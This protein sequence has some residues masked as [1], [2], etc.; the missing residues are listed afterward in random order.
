M[1]IRVTN[2]AEKKVILDGLETE[3]TWLTF[4]ADIRGLLIFREYLFDEII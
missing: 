3:G 4:L 1:S 2:T